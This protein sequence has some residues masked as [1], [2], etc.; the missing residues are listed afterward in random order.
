[1]KTRSGCS[2]E[3]DATIGRVSAPAVWD[4]KDGMCLFHPRFAASQT[5]PDRTIK[6]CAVDKFSWSSL[7]RGKDDSTNVF[8]VMQEERAHDTLD[9]LVDASSLFVNR[10][11]AVPALLQADFDL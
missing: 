8:T 2:T 5:R 9:S 1:M 11:G 4:G 6:L 10:V 7:D 3:V